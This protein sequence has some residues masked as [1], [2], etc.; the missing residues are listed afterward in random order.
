MRQSEI[1]SAAATIFGMTIAYDRQLQEGLF[2]IYSFWLAKQQ[3]QKSAVPQLSNLLISSFNI[4]LYSR[5]HKF[6]KCTDLLPEGTE[7]LWI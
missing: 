2:D 6:P 7:S 4:F 3:P 5:K 1:Y